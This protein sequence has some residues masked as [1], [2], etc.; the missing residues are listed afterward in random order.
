MN[1]GVA[2]GIPRCLGGMNTAD[3]SP[4]NLL[5]LLCAP[6]RLRKK[7]GA[8]CADVAALAA[9]GNARTSC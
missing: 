7:A 2:S 6:L 9:V 5:I 4:I 8:I 1:R 3:T